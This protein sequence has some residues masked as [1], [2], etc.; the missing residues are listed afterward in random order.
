M[1][2]MNLTGDLMM[3]NYES[4]SELILTHGPVDPKRLKQVENEITAGL[5]NEKTIG[6]TLDTL[7]RL[8]ATNSTAFAQLIPDPDKRAKILATNAYAALKGM[9]PHQAWLEF[10]D[11]LV[12]GRT[13]LTKA[14]L[15]K[16]NKMVTD[17]DIPSYMRA[18]TAA[19]AEALYNK[20]VPWDVVEKVIEDYK[21]D[22]PYEVDFQEKHPGKTGDI[23]EEALE[24]S[25]PEGSKS[26]YN[27]NSNTY[28]IQDEAGM[29]LQVMDKEKFIATHTAVGAIK[30]Y[31][32]EHWLA[33]R[34]EKG[35]DRLFS[36]ISNELRLSTDPTRLQGS[37]LSRETINNTRTTDDVFLNLFNSINKD[38]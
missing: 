23:L 27:P 5:Y 4:A 1:L 14:E 17:Q 12:G 6:Q 32:K 33:H 30:R 7:N 2:T 8:S 37:Q 9:S 34:M 22:E 15:T 10:N 36:L 16:S 26:F 24:K 38:Y 28:D 31:N 21:E 3:G 29:T 13:K 25:T 11:P 18:E 20:G 19:M 35:T